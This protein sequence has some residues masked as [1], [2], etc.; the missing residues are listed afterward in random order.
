MIV[1]IYFNSSVHPFLLSLVYSS[2]NTYSVYYIYELLYINS[3]IAKETFINSTCM[4]AYIK[5]K[6]IF[7][8]N[9]VNNAVKLT[10]RFCTLR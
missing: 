9:I 3:K 5:G 7:V 2:Y 6:I 10:K 1:I 8:C 4:D